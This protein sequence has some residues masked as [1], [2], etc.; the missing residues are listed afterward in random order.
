MVKVIQFPKMCCGVPMR[1]WQQYN[2]TY[3]ECRKCDGENA[4]P[5]FLPPI[6]VDVVLDPK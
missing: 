1:F 2:R 5:K 4:K 3:S 6:K